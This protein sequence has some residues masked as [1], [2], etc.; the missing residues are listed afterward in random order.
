[1][2]APFRKQPWYRRRCLW[3]E[4][5]ENACDSREPFSVGVCSWC[6]FSLWL[7]GNEWRHDV[8]T[9]RRR[10]FCT[11]R[12]DFV[13]DSLVADPSMKVTTSTVQNLAHSFQFTS[14]HVYFGLQ[15][16]VILFQIDHSHRCL[17]FLHASHFAWSLCRLVVPLP[18]LPV[19]II[20]AV[21]RNGLRATFS[22]TI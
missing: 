21:L 9:E 1:M 18:S 4:R 3:L 19:G 10:S 13:S 8:E 17:L 20:F 12:S 2:D 15:P 14:Q 22:F 6:C 5:I 16:Q 11:E 7:H